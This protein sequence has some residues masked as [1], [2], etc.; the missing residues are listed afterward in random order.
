[1]SA[2]TWP[3]HASEAF[4]RL[5]IERMQVTVQSGTV[6]TDPKKRLLGARG[7]TPRGRSIV[8]APWT[9][10]VI[11]IAVI[12]LPALLKLRRNRSVRVALAVAGIDIGTV[13]ARNG[14]VARAS[15]ATIVL[16]SGL[17]LRRQVA[18]GVA[19]AVAGADV[20]AVAARRWVYRDTVLNLMNLT[21]L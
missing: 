15:A 11:I 13:S 21:E 8:T 7:L 17:F 12:A 18:V 5:G 10:L 14:I 1:M 3:A 16:P 19:H 2:L 6:T 9:A 20:P 4:A